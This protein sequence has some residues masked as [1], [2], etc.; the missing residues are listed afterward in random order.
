MVKVLF[1]D[2]EFTR[3]LKQASHTLNS[4]QRDAEAG[5]YAWACFKAQQAAEFGIKALLRGFGLSA[6]GHSILALLRQAGRE[7]L[8]LPTELERWARI[9]DRHYIP[10]RYPNAY[11]SGSPFE[12]YDEKTAQE[13]LNTAQ[14]VIEAIREA[15]EHYG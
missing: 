2:E 15:R 13:A 14:A 10:P 11:P 1:D 4:A 3:W 12:F 9:L 6:V 5:D 8:A 7:G